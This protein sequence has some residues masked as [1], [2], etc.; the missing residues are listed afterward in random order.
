MSESTEALLLAKVEQL[1]A[2]VSRLLERTPETNRKWVGPTELA[3]RLGVSV[4]TIANWRESG[5]IR[6]SSF[7]RSGRSFEFHVD[8]VLND[9]EVR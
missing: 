5:T 2:D 7:R 8:A 6:T 3:K 4:R 1:S 9:L